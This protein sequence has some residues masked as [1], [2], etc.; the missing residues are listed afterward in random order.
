MKRQ[1]MKIQLDNDIYDDYMEPLSNI[2]EDYQKFSIYLKEYEKNSQ[3]I[4]TGFVGGVPILGDMGNEDVYVDGQDAHTLVIGSTGS[5]KTRLVVMPTV[6]LLGWANESMIISDPKAEI[7]Y[8][9]AGELEDQ[10]YRIVVLNFREPNL[11]DTWNPLDIPYRFYKSGNIDR[12]CE[13]VNDI[14][15]N[16][17][18]ADQKDTDPF[19]MNSAA[20]MFFGLVLTLF[21]LCIDGM[22][23]EMAVNISNVL[24]L[25]RQLFEQGKP[26]KTA[27]WKYVQNDEVIAPALSGIVMTINETRAGILS[28]FDQKVRFFVYQPNLMDMLANNS[29]RVDKISDE[30]T[31]VYLIMPDEKTTYHTLISLFVKQSYEY[32]IFSAQSNQKAQLKIRLNYILDEFSSLPTIKDFP[33][34]ITAARSRNI[35]FHLTMQS[36]HQL[37]QR[38]GDETETIQSNCGNWI[39]LTSRE[40]PLLDELSKLCGVVQ[41]GKIPLVSISALQH[42]SK[43][44]GQA[45]ILAGRKHPF[46]AE[47]PDIDIYDNNKYR[48]RK[49]FMNGSRRVRVEICG[50]D[51]ANEIMGRNGKEL[52]FDK[53]I[54]DK[55]NESILNG[56]DDIDIEERLNDISIS[57]DEIEQTL[58]FEYGEAV[59]NGYELYNNG[60]YDEAKRFFVEAISY[61]PEKSRACD[62]ENN[63]AYMLRRNEIANVEIDGVSYTVPEILEKGVNEKKTFFLINM[64]LYCCQI[65]HSIELSRGDFYIKKISMKNVDDAKQWWE[66]VAENGEVEGYIVLFWLYTYRL[67]DNSSVGSK[68]DIAN[69]L[70][71]QYKI[72]TSYY[73]S[74]YFQAFNE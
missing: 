41:Q 13:M 31:A 16:I 27:I 59:N 28:T 24:R 22:Q 17:I 55:S 33:T 19:W 50:N 15:K 60:K 67:I 1:N 48:V 8:R 7:Y 73:D 51:I 20:D 49:N 44:S 58:F 5:K 32:L 61:W 47:L 3:S 63:L 42:L 40:V 53:I 54:N 39:F 35:R 4:N 71:S 72:D 26:D 9:T 21:K 69:I 10:G 18:A 56:I 62:S 43:E 38:Y 34:M 57:E 36:K 6:R 37:R 66:G 65:D 12:A 23:S 70:E 68:I 14:A 64:A 11:G 52:I 45:L 30:K 2:R 25:R 29:I 46:Y 74:Q